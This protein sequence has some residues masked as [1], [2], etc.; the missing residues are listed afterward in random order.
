M[1][2]ADD[3]LISAHVA[4]SLA[5]ENIGAFLDIQTHDGGLSYCGGQ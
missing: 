1:C 4:E 5:V 2:F 3:A